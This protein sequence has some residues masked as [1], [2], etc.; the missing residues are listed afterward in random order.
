M[1][2][3]WKRERD[4]EKERERE[5]ERN[6]PRINGSD[7]RGPP[8]RCSLR[9]PFSLSLSLEQRNDHGCPAPGPNEANVLPQNAII[10]LPVYEG[11]AS[12]HL[13]SAQHTTYTHTHHTCTRTRTRTHTH[14]HTHTHTTYTHTTYNTHT[15]THLLLSLLLRQ[16]AYGNNKTNRAGPDVVNER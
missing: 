4:R 8:R 10:T 16:A 5:R 9:Q 2:E 12:L 6:G 1:A 7:C 11:L 3:K 13:A 15:Y 14:T